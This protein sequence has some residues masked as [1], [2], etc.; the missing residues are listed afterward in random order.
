MFGLPSAFPGDTRGTKGIESDTPNTG[1]RIEAIE[2]VA[3]YL[4]KE[5]K[6][7]VEAAVAAS[8][9]ELLKMLKEGTVDIAY[10]NGFGYVLGVSDSI[11]LVPLVSPG[12][13]DGS[14]NTYNSCIISSPSSGITSMADLVASAERRSFAFVNPTST[15]GHL[16]PRLYLTKMGTKS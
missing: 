12:N 1:K 8:A 15:S 2:P 6:M 9:T 10:I 4:S 3:T 11:P 5:L 14:P 16:I 13:A 7:P